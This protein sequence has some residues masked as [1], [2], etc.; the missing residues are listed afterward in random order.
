MRGEKCPY[1]FIKARL[2][3]ED[4]GPGDCLKVI[5]DFPPAWERV[6]ASFSVL[7]HRLISSEQESDGA[8]AFLFCCGGP[9]E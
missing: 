3:M 7:G 2:A 9:S 1:T 5:L 8:R 6:P 4:L